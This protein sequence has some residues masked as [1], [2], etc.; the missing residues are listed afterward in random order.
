MKLYRYFNP[1]KDIF[2]GVSE[3]GIDSLEDINK[4]RELLPRNYNNHYI[5]RRITTEKQL[6]EMF[7]AKGGRPQKKVPYYLTLGCCDEWFFGKKHFFG[8]LVFDLWEFDPDVLSFTYGDSIPTFMEEFNDGKEYRK[9]VYTLEEIQYVIQKYGYPQQWN[10]FAEKGPENYIEVQSWS[11]Q[12]LIKYRQCG[13]SSN[14]GISAYAPLIISRM[15][16]AKGISESGQ[17]SYTEC[18][19]AVRTNSWW[20]WF[21]SYIK[22]TDSRI[23]LSNWVH[24]SAHAY[25]CAFMAFVIASFENLNEID[26]KTLVL[27]ALY[28]D[29]GRGYYDQGRSHGQIG[30]DIVNRYIGSEENINLERLRYAIRVHDAPEHS[31]REDAILQRLRDVDTLDYLRLGFGQYDPE[32]LRTEEAKKMIRF[33][34]ELNIYS[35]FNYDTIMDLIS[36][37]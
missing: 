34:L 19:K 5:Q 25:K 1:E 35:Y 12:P 28:H 13:Y 9:N 7:K 15:L 4:Y 6:Y 27:A 17:R 32:L 22:H 23:F 33:A 24:G 18:I 2:A 10:T 3:L 30:A 14:E 26:T 11:D 21:T 16:Y 29:I 8:S 31:T 36:E 37:R 20:K